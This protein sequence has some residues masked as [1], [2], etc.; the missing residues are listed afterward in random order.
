[1]EKVRIIVANRSPKFRNSE[2]VRMPIWYLDGQ[3]LIL[4]DNFGQTQLP[5]N[6]S[7][8]LVNLMLIDYRKIARH[9]KAEHTE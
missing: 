1:M 7:E 3:M 4:S 2:I 9:V 6:F 8:K 5:S